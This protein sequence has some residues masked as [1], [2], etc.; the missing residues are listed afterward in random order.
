MAEIINLRMARKRK[1][2]AD[3]AAQAETNRL[4]F[5]R[6]KME[7]ARTEAEKTLAERRLDSQRLD[8]DD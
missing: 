8:K 4:V 1:K 2:R 7:K 3:D 5:G 6:G